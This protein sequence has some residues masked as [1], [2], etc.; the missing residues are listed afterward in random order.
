MRG[1]DHPFIFEQRIIRFG[2][3]IA[4]HIQCRAA[5][6]SGIERILKCFFIDNFTARGVDQK[7]ILFHQR[8]PGFIHQIACLIGQGAVQR[9]EI[10]LGKQSIQRS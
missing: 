3:F 6:T 4:Q 9:D 1:D 7:R 2:R 5:E 10:T 8:E